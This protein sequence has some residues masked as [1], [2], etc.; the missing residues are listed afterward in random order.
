[1]DLKIYSLE[2]NPWLWLCDFHLRSRVISFIFAGY[3]AVQHHP[4]GSGQR[5]Y[6]RGHRGRGGNQRLAIRLQESVNQL[7]VACMVRYRHSTVSNVIFFQT[8]VEIH[9]DAV[10]IRIQLWGGAGLHINIMSK[11]RISLIFLQIC[12]SCYK[13]PWIR[14]LYFRIRIQILLFSSVTSKMPTKNI[15]FSSHLFCLLHSLGTFTS[16]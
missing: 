14:T 2:R 7:L 15:F 8:H 5:A 9:R 16:V 6:Q 10:R 12:L 1:M 4:G 11:Q 3:R 13:I